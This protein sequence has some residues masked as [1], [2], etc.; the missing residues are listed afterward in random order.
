VPRLVLAAISAIFLLGYAAYEVVTTWVY[1]RNAPLKGPC[2]AWLDSPQAR[3]VSLKG[4]VLDVDQIVLESDEGDFETLENRKEGLSFKPYP[5][6]PNWVAAWIPIKSEWQGNYGLVRAVYR[7]ESKDALK[8]L[9]DFERADERKKEKMW[10]DPTPIRRLSR[11]GVLPGKADK[12]STES[13]MKAYGPRASPN[14]M[15]VIAGDPP[16]LGPP[17]L[18]ILSG[19]LGVAALAFV[20]RKRPGADLSA[21]QLITNVNVSDVKLELGALDEIREEERARRNRKI[22]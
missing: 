4:C 14:L 17:T 6:P 13:L 3:W 9:N 22:D 12:P 8:W 1:P 2:D 10:E 11:P 15:A 20:T 5:T 7:L 16:P 18:G 21:E 19:I